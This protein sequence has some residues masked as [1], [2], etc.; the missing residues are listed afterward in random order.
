MSLI[1]NKTVDVKR[2]NV[3]LTINAE[4]VDRYIA[5]GYDLIDKTGNVIKKSVPTDVNSLK[6]DYERQLSEN[7]QLKEQIALLKAQLIDQNMVKSEKTTTAKRTTT[8]K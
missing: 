2:G 6:A 1:D 5:K 7:K 3:V 4:L 8:K